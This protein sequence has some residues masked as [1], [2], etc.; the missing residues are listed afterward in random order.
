MNQ[1]RKLSLG[2]R[3]SQARPTKALVF[4]ACAA[5][6]AATMIVGFTWGGWVTGSTAV[7]V[8]EARADEAVAQRLAPMC[9]MRAKADP[10]SN[11]K[12]KE[13][14]DVSSWGYGEFVQ[15]QGWA[16]MPGEKDPDRHVAEAC[17]KLL[18]TS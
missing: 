11:M 7:R 15:K 10:A 5:S 13:L 3:W 18:M 4:W 9:V 2:E 1:D 6:V 14:K 12:M 17:A 16:T 8:A